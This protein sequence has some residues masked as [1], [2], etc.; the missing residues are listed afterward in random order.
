MIV[1]QWPTVAFP[2]V[3]SD[4]PINVA[5]RKEALITTKF[6]SRNALFRS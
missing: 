1:E 5:H 6:K 3:Q 4:N 2:V